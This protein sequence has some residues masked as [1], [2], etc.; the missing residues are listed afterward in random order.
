MSYANPCS[1]SISYANRREADI[2]RG[3][4]PFESDVELDRRDR[5]CDAWIE[6]TIGKPRVAITYCRQCNWLLRAAWMAQELL[7]T[8]AED[9]GEVALLP[10]DRRRIPDRGRRR[11]CLGAQARRRLSRCEDAEAARPRPDRSR[12]A[13]SATSDS[14]SASGQQSRAPPTCSPARTSRS[15]RDHGAAADAGRPAARGISSRISRR[16]A[17][18]TIEEAYEVADAIERGDLDDLKDELGDL[19]LQ[20]VF[21]ARMAEEA[22]AFAFGDVVEAITDQADPAPSARLRR[23]RRRRRRRGEGALGDDQGRGKGRARR[24]PLRR[25]A[26]PATRACSPTCRSPCPR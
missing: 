22:G 18:Y 11:A 26:R 5:A 6:A 20:V 15:D 10:V 17:P 1:I 19:L 7:S 21:H 14:S 16:I 9:L 4:R 2:V 24:A 23:W 25:E 12:R 3:D 8:F 13:I